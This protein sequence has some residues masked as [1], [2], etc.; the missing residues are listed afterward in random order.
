[1]K[2]WVWSKL[3]K[4]FLH[5]LP[6]FWHVSWF[7]KIHSFALHFEKS[8]DMPKIWQKNKEKPCSTCLIKPISPRNFQNQGFR[9]PI[10][11]YW[12]KFL[13]NFVLQVALVLVTQITWTLN[14][15]RMKM[16]MIM[17]IRMKKK[18]LMRR[19]KRKKNKKKLSMEFFFS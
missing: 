1:M 12:T 14:M 17:N 7:F 15:M 13:Q 19:T 6:N 9:Y 2:K 8:S 11:H 10:R 4:A 3:N 18:L 5:F 16:M